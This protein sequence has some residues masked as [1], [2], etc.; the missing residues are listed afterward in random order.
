MYVK[1]SFTVVNLHV[2]L[3]NN[4]VYGRA[5]LHRVV[6][7]LTDDKRG[8]DYDDGLCQPTAAAVRRGAGR[9]PCRA[10]PDHR[11]TGEATVE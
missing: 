10:R 5:C 7:R 11:H 8:D 9:T 6:R 4:A 1:R 2:L 3:S